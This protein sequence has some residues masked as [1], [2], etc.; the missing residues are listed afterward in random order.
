MLLN[1]T[2]MT[3][4]NAHNWWRK[5]YMLM[6]WLITWLLKKQQHLDST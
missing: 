6:V 2:Q 4:N 1:I 3:S 5:D